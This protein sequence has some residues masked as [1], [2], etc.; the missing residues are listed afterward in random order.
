MNTRKER[1]LP[2]LIKYKPCRS[3]ENLPVLKFGKPKMREYP[4]QPETKRSII[5]RRTMKML[6]TFLIRYNVN[7]T[8]IFTCPREKKSHGNLIS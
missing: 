8:P 5:C 7:G 6:S 2:N 3:K 1:D 4:K